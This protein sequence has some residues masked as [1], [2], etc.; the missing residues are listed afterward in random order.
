LQETASAAW[1]QMWM[2]KPSAI[3]KL[4]RKQEGKSISVNVELFRVG[5]TNLNDAVSI[6]P[7]VSDRNK[8]L[9]YMPARIQER[10]T[11]Y[12][13]TL[14][15]K[16]LGFPYISFISSRIGL[17]MPSLCAADR[18]RA[19]C[20][21]GREMY[22]IVCNGVWFGANCV[23]GPFSCVRHECCDGAGA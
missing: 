15:M 13:R 21:A 16:S 9:T 19:G 23:L 2:V 12:Q 17:V 7:I 11:P 22:A 6:A 4:R 8:Y 5:A 3:V 20:A 1:P 10:K 18:S 14:H